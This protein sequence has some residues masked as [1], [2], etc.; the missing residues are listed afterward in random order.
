MF[1][2]G[3]LNLPA[4]PG[5]GLAREGWIERGGV[6]RQ[7]L[8]YILPS[9]PLG[10]MSG[11]D[12]GNLELLDGA[13][14]FEDLMSFNPVPPSVKWRKEVGLTWRGTGERVVQ[15]SNAQQSTPVHSL[16]PIPT[17][18]GSSLGNMDCM[19]PLDYPIPAGHDL[20]PLSQF[21]HPCR[22]GYPVG[23][24]PDEIVHQCETPR[25][26]V[27]YWGV[28]MR[29]RPAELYLGAATYQRQLQFFTFY[30]ENVFGAETVREWLGE[31]K[32]A[33]LWYL[34]FAFKRYWAVRSSV[35]TYL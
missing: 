16:G 20:S 5:P 32:D 29:I 9:M 26:H 19:I 17:Q 25:L 3:P 18:G 31:I 14:L 27:E 7:R 21:P 6:E 30:D 23:P 10:A 15:N 28:H 11:K 34:V 1:F 24:V 13:P 22:A 2:T 4:L 8:R 35:E 33:M 12:A